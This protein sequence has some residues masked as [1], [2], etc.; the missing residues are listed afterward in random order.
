MKRLFDLAAATAG[1]LVL[2]P[3]LAVC[4]LAVRMSSPGP[5]FFRQQRV[6][7]N[8]QVFDILK[9]RTMRPADASAPQITIGRDPRIT[10]AGAFLRKW[11]LDELP[12][13]WNVVR[14]DMSLVGPRPEVPKYV[15]LY[16]AADR[17][18]VLSVRPGITDPCSIY[19]RNESE[20]LAEAEDPERFYVET[21]LP[22]KL[23]ISGQYV[24]SQSL[25]SDIGIIL[26]TLW[27]VVSKRT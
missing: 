27:S 2:L 11:K 26:Q 14:G 12:Q 1:L 9:F 18:L 25:P 6:G 13:L 24:R 15:A 17:A 22:E 19:L 4:A 5:I 21:L 20:I 23:R 16:P 3:V 7:L 8:G 10:P